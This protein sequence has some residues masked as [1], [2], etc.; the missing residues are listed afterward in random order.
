MAV[1]ER[2]TLDEEGPH[3][4]VLRH[5]AKVGGV[6][7]RGHLEIQILH[8]AGAEEMRLF[9]VVV[10]EVERVVPDV[11]LALVLTDVVSM[12]VCKGPPGSY[13]CL[14]GLVQYA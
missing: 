10:G 7:G 9:K 8:G 14:L 2:G 3:S 5:L 13:Y 12:E 4:W 11:L 6:R 1:E